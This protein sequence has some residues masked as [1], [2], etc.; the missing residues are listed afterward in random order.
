[1]LYL[2]QLITTTLNS[3][4]SSSISGETLTY[5][6][7][8]YGEQFESQQIIKP[9]ANVIQ[10]EEDFDDRSVLFGLISNLTRRL[11]THVPPT[12]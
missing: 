6:N 1:M 4:P 12:N 5:G 8:Y 10:E 3:T 2:P 9:R 11:E 7:P